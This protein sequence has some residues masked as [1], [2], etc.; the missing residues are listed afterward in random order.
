M[1][2]FAFD[3]QEWFLGK[4]E[5][6][7]ADAEARG[8]ERPGVCENLWAAGYIMA[9]LGCVVAGLVGLIVMWVIMPSC[10]AN[11]GVL[12]ETLII[13]VFVMV[14]S[15]TE[16]VGQGALPPAL[17]FVVAVW[18]AW[19][20]LTNN[21]DIQCNP[22]AN[23]NDP[24]TVVVGLVFTIIS[25]TWMTMRSAF[26][27][28]D[29]LRPGASSTLKTAE[30]DGEV[31]PEGTEL[32]ASAAATSRT[33]P[34]AIRASEG[35]DARPANEQATRYT[36]ATAPEGDEESGPSKARAVVAAPAE[37]DPASPAVHG[38]W[39]FHLVMAVGGAY[40][41][42]L[43]TNW[44]SAYGDGTPAANTETSSLSMWVRLASQLVTW[45]LY[46][47]VLLAPV[48]FPGREFGP[49]SAQRGGSDV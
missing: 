20:V 3:V 10:A 41:A 6:V 8:R 34:A 45:A 33:M 42:M 49:P 39:A 1:V 17:I 28:G 40:L 13:G 24:F 30:E 19:G 2:D 44:G 27:A 7:N 4:I 35:S 25:V 48:C 18:I 5:E 47:W 16:A 32:T 43:L 26:L 23:D 11:N 22:T 31:E 15:S 38:S 9:T 46:G 29:M 21:P 36:S 37:V 12:S 14:I